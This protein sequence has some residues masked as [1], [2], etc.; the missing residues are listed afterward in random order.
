[1][2][3]S[4]FGSEITSQDVLEDLEFFDDWEDRYRYIIDLGKK[5]PAMEPALKIESNLVKGCQSQ[6][7]ISHSYNPEQQNLDGRAASTCA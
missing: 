1:M 7:W 3:E 6:V 4:V 5:L 2:S